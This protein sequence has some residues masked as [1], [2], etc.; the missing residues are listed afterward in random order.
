MAW[1]LAALGIGADLFGGLLQ[2]SAQTMAN[3]R[4]IA[5]QREQR[6]MGRTHERHRVP[7]RN[8]RPRPQ[9]ALIPCSPY[10]KVEHQHQTSAQRPSALRTQQDGQSHPP[11]TKPCRSNSCKTS[12]S[13][14]ASCKR[15]G[16]RNA[17]ATQR[18]KVIM[19]QG[20]IR[21]EHGN[22]I[23]TTKTMVPWTASHKPNQ[24]PN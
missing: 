1:G 16:S 24:N 5:L 13:T 20:D 19:G 4:N 14:I 23:H 8:K 2:T 9:Q 11:P 6:G 22:V 21:D 10:R 18:D 12:S 17:M 7:T 3:R 15:S